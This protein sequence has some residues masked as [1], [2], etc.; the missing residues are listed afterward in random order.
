MG[1]LLSVN[2][3]LPHDVSWQGRMVHTGIWKAPVDGPRMVR[4]LNIEGDGQGDLNGHGGERRAVLVYQMDSYRYWQNQLGRNDFVYG[5]FGENFTVDGLPD[6]EVCVGDRYRIGSALFE[7]T[8]PR[9]TCYRLG[10]RMNKPEMAALLVKHGRPGFYFRVL[11][12]GEVEAG[13][14]ITQVASGP[15]RISVSEIDALLYMPGRSRDQ[16]KRAL[17]IPALSVGWRKSFETLLAEEERKGAVT[18][19]SAGFNAASS[20]KAPAWC[21]FRPLRVSRKVRESGNVTSLLLEPTDG[22]PIAT[23]LPGQFIVLRLEPASAPPLMR[24]YSL[25]GEPGASTYRVSVKREAHGA[26]STYVDDKLSVGDVVQ[27]SAARGSFTLRPGDTPVVLLSAGIGV[28]PVLAMLHAL[29]AEASTRDIWWLHGARNGREHPFAEETRGLLEAL[30][31]HHRR[32]YYSS[33]DPKD[34]PNADFDAARRLTTQALQELNLPSN[35]DFY[36]C[37]PSTFMS[38]LT[39]GL[40]ALGVARN[41]IHTEM[42]GAGASNTPGIAASPRPSPHVPAGPAGSGPLVTFART[43]LNVRWQPT[44]HSLLELA[45]ACDVPVRW[46]CRTGVCYTCETGLVA[47]NISYAPDPVDTPADGNL[48]ICCSHPQGDVVIDL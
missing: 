35:G 46:A 5:Q 24:S 9:V 2:V 45:E 8:Q 48:L 38:D 41:Q 7:V 43:G 10:I 21:G 12:E 33:P 39:A 32:I 22:Q 40:V 34:R 19:G 16:L 11:E 13:D 44:F 3:G 42:F 4:R 26:V 14:E 23:A 30:P 37:G 31:H 28:T 1:H 47:G 6:A 25:S 15:E 27:A 36:I 18:T 20:G 29:A 17:R